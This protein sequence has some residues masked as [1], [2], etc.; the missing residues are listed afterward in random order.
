MGGS[1]G[2]KI[3]VAP[4]LVMTALGASD[5]QNAIAQL[6]SL[7]VD[8]GYA[9]KDY[10]DGVLEREQSYPTGIEFP[11]C[12]V[13]MPHG[14]PEGVLGAAIA[15]GRCAEPVS[16]KRMDE[17]SQDVDVSIIAMLAVSDPAGHLDVLGKLIG[18][19]SDEESCRSI[20]EAPNSAAIAAILD[21]AINGE[22]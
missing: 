11:L 14:E 15:I 21:A 4:E 1:M 9:S 8:A 19:F 7:L 12:G 13:A 20:L 17:F 22:G 10:V 2:E 5:P 3:L 16:F 18:V 6:G